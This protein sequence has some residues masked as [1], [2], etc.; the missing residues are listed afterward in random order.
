MRRLHRKG[1]GGGGGVGVIILVVVI[2]LVIFWA[3]LKYASRQCSYD[4]QCSQDYY[5]GSDFKCH[6]HTIIERTVIVNDYATPAVILGIAL[7]IVALIIRSD[8]LGNL[9]ERWT[10]RSNHSSGKNH[11]DGRAKEQEHHCYYNC[12]EHPMHPQYKE[13]YWQKK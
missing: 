5:C 7:I 6:Q 9:R 2:I 8:I 10:S 11:R 12:A 1:A 13:M 3:L 4:T